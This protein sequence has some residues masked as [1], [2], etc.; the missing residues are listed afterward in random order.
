MA[1]P[2]ESCLNCLSSVNLLNRTTGKKENVEQMSGKKYC[3]RQSDA[4]QTV[5]NRIQK[6]EWRMNGYIHIH[7][8]YTFVYIQIEVHKASPR[9]NTSKKRKDEMKEKNINTLK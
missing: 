2:D 5:K 6:H 9:S 1:K 8:T 3:K 4:E 7:I